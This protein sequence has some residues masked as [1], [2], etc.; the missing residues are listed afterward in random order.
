MAKQVEDLRQWLSGE[1]ERIAL[2]AAL[3]YRRML[4]DFARIL[5]SC[6][7]RDGLKM[8]AIAERTA[9]PLWRLESFEQGAVAASWSE[10]LLLAPVYGV[11]LSFITRRLKSVLAKVSGDDLSSIEAYLQ[12]HRG[13]TPTL[14]QA[15]RERIGEKLRAPL[16]ERFVDVTIA[17]WPSCFPPSLSTLLSVEVEMLIAQLRCMNACIARLQADGAERRETL[18]GVHRSLICVATSL[19]WQ[20]RRHCL[21]EYGG[22]KSALH[23]EATTQEK[24]MYF[25]GEGIKQCRAMVLDAASRLAPFARSGE[26]RGDSDLPLKAE[27]PPSSS[28]LYAF[29]SP[30]LEDALIHSVLRLA[31]AATRLVSIEEK[32]S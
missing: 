15:D 16:N 20:L 1:H 24:T 14:R 9:V 22:S 31:S 2:R 10:S 29:R 7:R 25:V 27:R 8:E 19:E 13:M 17:D 6:R 18:S 5:T 26:G 11:R 12:C 23:G 4:D 32:V 30:A 28:C 3:A 21:S